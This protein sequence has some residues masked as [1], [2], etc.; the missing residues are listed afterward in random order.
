LPSSLG[1][2]Q[3][4]NPKWESFVTGTVVPLIAKGLALDSPFTASLYKLLFY[5]TGSFFKPHRDTEKED[6]MFGTL[7]IQLPSKYSGGELLVKHAD[8]SQSFEFGTILEKKKGK[9]TKK[10]KAGDTGSSATDFTTYFAALYC[11]CEHEILP[12]TS[13][14]RAC[15]VYNLVSGKDAVLPK[16]PPSDEGIKQELITALNKWPKGEPSILAYYLAHKYTKSSLSFNTLKTTDKHVATLLQAVAPAA[17]LKV[18]VCLFKGKMSGAAGY[19][20]D[21][22]E[23]GGSMHYSMKGRHP[24]PPADVEFCEDLDEEGVETEYMLSCMTALDGQKFP[25]KT[26]YGGDE[27]TVQTESELEVIPV[28]V[29]KNGPPDDLHLSPT[30]T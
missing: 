8:K 29:F 16:L 4:L 26:A 7:V 6:G 24:R 30:G 19:H 9:G 20:L 11:D 14:Y 25:H 23:D 22:D 2:L 5:E 15:L 28:D 27:F 18:Y 3:I 1:I 12:V 17:K 13:G 21:L 10:A